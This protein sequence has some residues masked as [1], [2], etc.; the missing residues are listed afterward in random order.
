[1]KCNLTFINFKKTSK[2]IQKKENKRKKKEKKKLVQSTIYIPI[3]DPICVGGA[4]G[5]ADDNALCGFALFRLL[6]APGKTRLKKN[7]TN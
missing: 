4:N 5:T 2:N 6:V 3:S 1:M 7:L